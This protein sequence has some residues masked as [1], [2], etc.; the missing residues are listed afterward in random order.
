[1][2]SGLVQQTGTGERLA[3]ASRTGENTVGGILAWTGRIGHYETAGGQ[4][5][6]RARDQGFARRHR[7]IFQCSAADLDTTSGAGVVQL[8]CVCPF[9]EMHRVAGFREGR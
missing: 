8:L 4:S 6:A 5:A 3:Y 2:W 1:M 7:G 9:I